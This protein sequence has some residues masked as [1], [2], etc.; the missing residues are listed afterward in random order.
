MLL[1]VLFINEIHATVFL[2]FQTST[3]MKLLPAGIV[4]LLIVGT[5]AQWYRFPIERDKG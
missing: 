3:T 2:F 4:L 5:N 1:I